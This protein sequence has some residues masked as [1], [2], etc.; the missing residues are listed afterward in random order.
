M[1]HHMSH[2]VRLSNKQAPYRLELGSGVLTP[3]YMLADKIRPRARS[4]RGRLIIYQRFTKLGVKHAAN[5]TPDDP[6]EG[7]VARGR[8]VWNLPTLSA[9]P[10]PGRSGCRFKAGTRNQRYLHLDMRSFR[11]GTP[12][13]GAV[14]KTVVRVPYRGFAPT[15]SAE[16]LRLGRVLI[17]RVL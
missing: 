17:N 10:C 5:R 1:S 14:S 7:H 4:L 16:S 15:G 11:R 2:L 12:L 3:H 13:A 9:A 8:G 6:S